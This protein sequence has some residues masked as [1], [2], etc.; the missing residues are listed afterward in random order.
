MCGL[1]PLGQALQTLTG[2]KTKEAG[3][4]SAS[5][6]Q[7]NDNVQTWLRVDH[8]Q[9]AIPSPTHSEFEPLLELLRLLLALCWL[10]GTT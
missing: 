5:Q 7:E 9:L 6:C 8:G 10:L 3:T 2:P 1:T 4:T